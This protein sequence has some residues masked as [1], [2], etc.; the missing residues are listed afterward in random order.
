MVQL[1]SVNFVEDSFTLQYQKRPSK[2]L[3]VEQQKSQP[4]LRSTSCILLYSLGRP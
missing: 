4:A 3:G 2:N 1:M